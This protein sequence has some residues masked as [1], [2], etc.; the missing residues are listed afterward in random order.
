MTIWNILSF[1]L[2]L[3]PTFDMLCSYV[4]Y[5]RD[6]Y[7]KSK[8]VALLDT[9]IEASM[10]AIKHTGQT[11]VISPLFISLANALQGRFDRTRDTTGVDEAID[12]MQSEINLVPEDD[13]VL[14]VL[15][16][17][18]GIA[19]RVKFLSPS[20][21]VS[22]ILDSIASHRTALSRSLS[23][24]SGERREMLHSLSLSLW[25]AFEFTL[26]LSYL[27]EGIQLGLKSIGS[28]PEGHSSLYKRIFDLGRM[29]DAR[30]TALQIFADGE[31]AIGLMLRAI[32]LAGQ[33]GDSYVVADMVNALG[34]AMLNK[35]SMRLEKTDLSEAVHVFKTALEIAPNNHIHLPDI[36]QN[37]GRALVM[38]STKDDDPAKLESA[39]SNLRRSVELTKP[40]FRDLG[41]RL[42][43][44][45]I[46][47]QMKFDQTQELTLIQ[48]AISC[49]QRAF[50]LEPRG[51]GHIGVRARELSGA[52]GVRC[53]AVGERMDIDD[54]IAL[55]ELDIEAVEANGNGAFLQALE[56]LGLVFL[57]RYHANRDIQDIRAA[58]SAFER[59]INAATPD[60]SLIS[61]F[62]DKLGMVYEEKYAATC[63][64]P[65]LEAAIRF[66]RKVTAATPPAH[67][68]L[69]FYRISLAK[70]LRIAYRDTSVF[71]YVEE[72]IRLQKAVTEGVS[73][74][75]G[76][77][78]PWYMEL[79]Y[80]SL[81]IHDKTSD[82]AYLQRGLELMAKAGSFV[83]DSGLVDVPQRASA[84]AMMSTVLQSTR[85]EV[86]QAV[87]YYK[88]A[89]LAP[90]GPTLSRLKAARMWAEDA[91][92]FD[93]QSS[94]E[95]YGRAI[96]LISEF[97]GLEQ[98]QSRRHRNIAQ[99]SKLSRAAA[100]TALD[101]G[102]VAKALDWL[103]R[104]RCL[105]WAQLNSLRTP[106]N[107]LKLV[108]EQLAER[109]VAVSGALERLS[110]SKANVDLA[111]EW[112]ELVS[113]V[114]EK[115]GFEG[116]LIPKTFDMRELPPHGTVVIINAH[117]T[118]C[119]ALALQAGWSDPRH[120]PLPLFSLDKAMKMVERLRACQREAGV[121]MR[122]GNDEDTDAGDAEERAVG[123]YRRKARE[124]RLLDD[125][126]DLWLW[127]VRPILEGLGCLV[128]QL[129]SMDVVSI[130]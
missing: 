24:C 23:S 20:N 46:A 59:A 71:K 28:T 54:I 75:H 98:T 111:I 95:G 103:E 85:K 9:I 49:F 115:P 97:I 35:Y 101:A 113:K 73:Q 109:V 44:L 127:V 39:L 45:G 120:I 51:S 55:V 63:Q 10:K 19:Q 62:L 11:A 107:E 77:L 84:L 18:L 37:Y 104:G 106:V 76:M 129:Y 14:P 57:N 31:E 79:A 100:A 81:E 47:L 108:D 123:R 3:E 86:E 26:Q 1:N 50:E 90:F 69:P 117:D 65:D 25:K 34:F 7:D 48:E 92:S 125:L 89:A 78:G 42:H 6:L 96:D 8:I 110:G 114:R 82:G 130:D 52:L 94:L 21:R 40:E 70:S 83:P 126:R 87:G 72:A 88:E 112:K 118:R 13:P 124:H 2:T 119:D 33:Q 74:H 99:I 116:F 91:R 41:R 27:E 5:F 122:G 15:L 32:D 17:Q 43:G 105:V 38:L 67:A 12:V 64:L 66:R 93:L 58:I 80:S 61:S 29:L 36:L 56:D 30:L 60:H 4:S 22:D 53:S 68:K 128:R 121:R 102:E 16:H